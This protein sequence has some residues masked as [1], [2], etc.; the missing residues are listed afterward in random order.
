MSSLYRVLCVT[1]LTLSSALP[2]IAQAVEDPVSHGHYIAQI[3]GCFDCHSPRGEN[4]APQ[5]EKGLIGGTIGFE[6]PGVGIFWPPNLT[7][8]PAALGEW[9]DQ[10]IITAIRTGKRPDGRGLVPIMPWPAF[11][12]MTDTDVTALVAYLRA[13]PKV[14]NAVPAIAANGGE[15]K[16]PY[17]SVVMPK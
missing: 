2:A 4:G 10:E 14:S 16:G 11:A 17:F 15:A 9:S 3:A 1:S 12:V 5:P 6:L 7:S 8:D 13:E